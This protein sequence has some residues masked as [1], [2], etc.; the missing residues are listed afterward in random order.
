[1]TNLEL[2][3]PFYYFPRQS[4]AHVSWT[5]VNGADVSDMPKE[6]VGI[7]FVRYLNALTRTPFLAHSTARLDA[8]CFT[9]ESVGQSEHSSQG[10]GVHACLPALEALYGACGCTKRELED[11]KK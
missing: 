5:V 8:R 3:V 1:M 6:V 4:R 10:G 2:L 11:S 7:F 9:A